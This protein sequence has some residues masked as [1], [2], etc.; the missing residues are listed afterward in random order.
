M[1][2]LASLNW[3]IGY[4]LSYS[5]QDSIRKSSTETSL[6]PLFHPLT[7]TLAKPFLDSLFTSWHVLVKGCKAMQLFTPWQGCLASFRSYVSAKTCIG[8]CCCAATALLH[9]HPV[10]RRNN[11]T[12]CLTA[13]NR[14][15][16]EEASS[17]FWLAKVRENVYLRGRGM[18]VGM[19]KTIAKF[20]RIAKNTFIWNSGFLHSDKT[21][22]ALKNVIKIKMFISVC[23]L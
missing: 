9:D 17:C 13:I 7:F 10:V 4:K 1:R 12:I 11:W 15:E 23:Q 3:S 5:Y 18:S 8:I 16:D 21:D 6:K 22:I 19:M 2:S 14:L 20:L